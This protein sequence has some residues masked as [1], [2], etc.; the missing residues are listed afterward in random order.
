MPRFPLALGL[1][2]LVTS[3]V[4]SGP[5]S[6]ED[7]PPPPPQ[8]TPLEA[9]FLPLKERM[10]TLPPFLGNTDVKLHLRSYSF[11]RVRPDDTQN[12]AWAFGG[13]ITY[14]SGWLLDTFA[15]GATMYGSAP[16]YAPEDKDGTLLLKP[17]A[18]GLLR[19]GRSVGRPTLPGLRP[20]QGLPPARRPDLHQP[21]GQ[22][23]DAQH[24]PG[25]DARRPGGVGA[26]PQ[27][28]PLADQAEELRR[29]HQHVPA[30]RGPG[31]E[32]RRGRPLRRTADTARGPAHRPEQ[33]VR[34][35]HLQHYLCGS[36]LPASPERGLEAAPGRAVHRP[37]RC[38][39]GASAR[40]ERHV[41][42]GHPGGRGAHPGDLPGPGSHPEPSRSRAPATTSRPPGGPSP[43]TSRASSWTSTA[44]GRRR[45]WSARRTISRRS[46]PACTA[47]ST[48]C[49]DGM[50]SLRPRAGTRPTR[51]S[52]T[53]R[54]TIGPPSRSPSS[55]GSGYACERP[56]S[57][58]RTPRDLATSSASSSTGTE[59]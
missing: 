18:E 58:S 13:R 29:V 10:A 9:L 30:G 54:S 3:A 4:W 12:E 31:R 47:T 1:A 16:L 35:E 11:N 7:A 39:R 8:P 45:S 2:L 21:T 50:P 37:A 26:I 40:G 41:P 5:A 19:S 59:T 22:P 53:S 55:R 46:S 32:R 23:D 43:D 51:R 33:P 25:R 27:R 15:M 44:P 17:G 48:S 14:Q 34:R 49:G 36:G 56:S 28:V 20:S 6:A 57:I 42:L 38:R 52:T 24:L